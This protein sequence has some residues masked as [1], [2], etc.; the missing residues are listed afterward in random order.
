MGEAIIRLMANPDMTD[1]NGVLQHEISVSMRQMPY[2]KYTWDTFLIVV[3]AIL[4]FFVV[5][6]YIYS[7]GIF[8]KVEF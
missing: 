1:C 2:P 5:L 8:T 3:V 4:P 6:A 7:A